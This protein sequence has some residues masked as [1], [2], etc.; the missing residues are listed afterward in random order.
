MLVKIYLLGY[1]HDDEL[2][3]FR[4]K[5]DNNI[6][7]YVYYNWRQGSEGNISREREKRQIKIEIKLGCRARSL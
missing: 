5:F 2:L 1:Y 3:N 6:Y 4:Y 7:I